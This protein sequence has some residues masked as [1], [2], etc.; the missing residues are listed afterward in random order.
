MLKPWEETRG[1]EDCVEVCWSSWSRYPMFIFEFKVW[2][3]MSMKRMIIIRYQLN[4]SA[5]DR[6]QYYRSQKFP[7]QV[8]EI[9]A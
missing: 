5:E 6:D 3:F 1:R 7:A 2:S 4:E 9:Q 8:V